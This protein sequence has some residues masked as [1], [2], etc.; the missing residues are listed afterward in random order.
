[1][2]TRTM[3]T[4]RSI[5][6]AVKKAR[7]TGRDEW[8]TDPA[9]KGSGRFTLRCAP[10]GHVVMMFRFTLDDGRRDIL[11]I[12]DY[13][14]AGR[15]GL[16]L[17]EGRTRAGEL[18]RLYMSGVRDLRTHLQAQEDGRKAAQLA[19]AQAQQKAERGSLQALCDAYVAHLGERPTARDARGLL[20]LHVVDA[21]PK[22]A[23]QP[24]AAIRAED[25]R[26]VLA[27]LIEAG[28]GRTASKVR[29]FLRAAYSLAMRA[30][31]DPSV[32]GT[33]A[34][35][36]VTANPADRL[37][38]LAQYTKAL[39]RVLTLA[40]LRAFWTRAKALPSSAAADALHACT[41]L[42]GQRPTQL[43]RLQRHDVDLDAGTVTLWDKKGRNRHD[44]P[45]VHRLPI[46]DELLPRLSARMQL[47][48]KPDAWVFSSTGKVHVRQESVA[49]VVKS[50][51]SD[52]EK[53]G[54]LERGKFSLRDLRRTAETMMAAMGV[55]SD[56]RAQ[57]QSH[58]LGGIQQR[59]YDRHD[60]LPE[61]VA[62]LRRWADRLHG[63]DYVPKV[64]PMRSPRGVW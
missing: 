43:V 44:K 47:S 57:I 63:R 46:P 36:D 42:G 56:V 59:H 39:D 5:S 25:L 16:T 6:A 9:P 17:E 21:F 52:M 19:Q 2:A 60:Y 12:G 40:E 38:S 61:K 51:C 28:K 10:S 33:L 62:V 55:S 1:M 27:K 13:D 11:R 7:V 32:P 49:D 8:E 29:A 26:D 20:R 14:E 31:L 34:D 15:A 53:A 54:E 41:L 30:G 22:L 23:A 64:V 45:R 35:F 24:A 48:H 37:P 4:T 58:G 50:I 3:V 18:A